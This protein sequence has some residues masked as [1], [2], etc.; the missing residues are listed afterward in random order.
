M[1]YAPRRAALLATAL[2]F[3]CSPTPTQT[4]LEPLPGA[5]NDALRAAAEANQVPVELLAATAYYQGR[6][7]LPA[8]PEV[9]PPAPEQAPP[10]E[11]IDP[12]A[13]ATPV[14]PQDLLDEH[15]S[16][17]QV[18]GVMFLRDDQVERGA[19]LTRSSPV[20][21][22]TSLAT[23]IAAAAALLSELAD[24]PQGGVVP[25]SPEAFAQAFARFVGADEAEVATLAS[26][27]LERL[28]RHGFDITMPDGERIVLSG[29]HPDEDELSQTSQ[30]LAAGAYPPVEFIA[31]P[32]HSSRN[33]GTVRFV[34][35][36]DIEGTMAGA[37]SVFKNAAK[38]TSAHYITRAS[39]GKVVQ[40]VAE[41]RKAWQCG[42]GYYNAN[43]IGIEHE[44]F[45]NKENGGG[46]YTD[47]QYRRS[48]Q[49]TCAIA[50]RYNIPIDR[51]H[52][53]GHGNVPRSGL[54]TQLCNDA[55]ANARKCGGKS[56]HYDPG[57][58]WQWSKYM[59]LVAECAAGKSLDE[60]NTTPPPPTT[61]V[62]V[63]DGQA[64]QRTA[65]TSDGFEHVFVLGGS[66]G[67]YEMVKAPQTGTFATTFTKL[68]PL[69]AFASN[70]AAGVDA[71]GRAA[72]FA[73]TTTKR[74]YVIR[75]QADGS[76][77]GGALQ[78]YT[79]LGGDSIE[80]EPSVARAA[81]G[82]LHAFV[83]RSDGSIGVIAETAPGGAFGA[84]ASLGGT[85]VTQPTAI[86]D[87]AGRLSVFAVTATGV[88]Q[89]SGQA[90]PG[91]AFTPWLSL[92]G[93]ATSV[94]TAVKLGDGRL[95]LFALGEGGA[96][97][98]RGQLATGGAFT[99]WQSLGG[100]LASN[101]AAV[102]NADG[103]FEVYG[104]GELNHLYRTAQNADGTWAAA[105][106]VLGTFSGSPAVVFSAGAT[107][108]VFGRGSDTRLYRG[109]PTAA[110]FE[111]WQ[112][113]GGVLASF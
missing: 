64:M 20:E 37:I 23:N 17:P 69:Y 8:A 109:S 12:E 56:G 85:F 54:V 93:V 58:Y 19:L 35:I 67:L 39:D 88:V 63:T 77:G 30:P 42:H 87:A 53:I 110:G 3:A 101:V 55:D 66:K 103:R 83:R 1:T 24:A 79:D 38:Q 86:A 25:R 13:A 113:L 5:R 112:S 105:T 81:D 11:A 49:L 6:F 21:V 7:D 65:Q 50:K 68:S 104:R 102:V 72:V 80:S 61:A 57:K 111:T 34:I 73:V 100:K 16:R 28:Y 15:A 75:Q 62:T 82:R 45:A 94:V 76:W 40:M 48:A 32:N 60:P 18:S 31:S 84:W 74:L 95:Q 99:P 22:R 47:V 46:Y 2:V 96:L 27:E 59:A 33:G 70:P 44:G 107:V 10:P 29:S 97:Q 26:Q 92:D 51:N 36:H 52:I 90:Q 71:N 91:A 4:T 14:E 78:G 108:E 9:E 98:T 106:D 41:S 89:V 43:S